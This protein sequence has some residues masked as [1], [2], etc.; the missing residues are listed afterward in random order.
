[1]LNHLRSILPAV[2]IGFL[3]VFFAAPGSVYAQGAFSAITTVHMNVEY[4]PGVSEADARKVADYLQNDYNYISDKI[5]LD[6]KKRLEVKIYDSVGKFLSATNQ[7]KPWR[8]AVYARGVLSLQPVQ[9]LVQRGIFEQSLSYEL[10]VALLDQTSGKGCPRW[11]RESFAVYHS[12][13]MADLSVP[14]GAKLS[15]FSDLDQDIQ[16]YPDPPQRE[17]VHFVLGQTMKFL[18]E[19]FGEEKAFKVYKA[20]NGTTPVED[21]F[22]RIFKQEFR[23]IERTWSNFIAAQ[24]DIFK[25]PSE[26]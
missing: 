1:M 12:G 6:F 18:V 22:K 16:Q 19:K 14:I 4:Q 25:K 17:D 15:Y 5:G 9:A 10:A 21:I 3:V 13:E 26:Q 20:F 24:T 7:K 2:I 11:L 8:G 23:T